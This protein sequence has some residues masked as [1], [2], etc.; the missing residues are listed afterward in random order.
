MYFL[1]EYKKNG[2]TPAQLG[3]Q[4]GSRFAQFWD[5]S[6]GFEEYVSG[7]LWNLQTLSTYIEVLESNESMIKIKWNPSI[8]ISNDWDVS[9]KELLEY[10]QNAFGEIAKY[11]G[12]TCS[13]VDDGKY[14]ILTLNKK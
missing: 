1:E 10:F 6:G 8:P 9:K 4:I 5:K 12:A 2:T 13:I 11:M 3:N 7:I 14:W